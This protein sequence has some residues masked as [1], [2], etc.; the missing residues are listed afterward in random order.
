M[1]AMSTEPIANGWGRVLVSLAEVQ[2][3]F[4]VCGGVAV[5]MYGVVRPT[6]AVDMCGWMSRIFVDS[7]VGL[8]Q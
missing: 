5:L 4:V 3:G 7:S 1:R 6:Q 8:N 2:V